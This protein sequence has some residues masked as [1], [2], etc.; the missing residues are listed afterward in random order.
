MIHGPTA[1]GKTQL[2]IEWSQ[3]RNCEILSCDARQIYKELNIGVA[4][5]SLE[6]LNKVRHMGIA[7]H[8]IHGSMTAISFAKWAKPLID[9]SLK[10]HGEIVIVGGSGLYAKSILFKS[11]SLPAENIELR[12]QLEIEWSKNP[13]NLINELKKVDQEYA[14]NCDLKNSRRVIR[15]LEIISTTGKKYSSL[16]TQ[17]VAKP[18][19][20]AMIHQF[21][22]WPEMKD[23]ETR[24]LARTKN[25][26]NSGLVEEAK[27]LEKHKDLRAM[28]T[29]GYKEI[30][31]NPEG[32]K[33]Q[34]LTKIALHTRQYAKRQMTWLK[35]ENE[36][37]KISIGPNAT[38]EMKNFNYSE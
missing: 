7:S 22:I 33:D 4:R 5:P 12:K 6:D 35:R 9:S 38:V 14:K 17:K 31:T 24:I 29:V 36:I 27:K 30:Y 37:K 20:H 21:A 8:T 16:R 13:D 11:D 25:M 15:A 10:K 32:S 26:L 18:N 34:F 3:E 19:F 1:A 23:L 2:A 28:Q